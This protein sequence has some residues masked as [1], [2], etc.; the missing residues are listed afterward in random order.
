MAKTWIIPDIHGYAE[1][2]RFL[3]E[4]QIKP[5]KNDYLI[6]L[7]DYI[8]RGGDSKGVIDIIMDLESQG[9]HVTAL[10]GNHEDVCLKAWEEAKKQKE[11]F[12]GRSSLHMQAYW[13]VLGGRKTL[14]SF[15]VSRTDEIPGK[16]IHWMRSLKYFVELDDFIAVH[17]GFNFK[18]DDPFSDTHAM[19]WIRDYEII[20]EKIKH[21]I[22]IH[23]HSPANLA[24]IELFI[25]NPDNFLFINLDNGIYIR[26]VTGY[27]NLVALELN[28]ME[29]K[30]QP[31]VDDEVV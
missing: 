29:Y 3:L 27:G 5:G 28:S 23:G 24:L 14:D 8:D 19:I 13:E 1:T 16:Y 31:V 7:G 21:K 9:Y 6:F 10:K 25:K 4:H 17:A 26:H 30:I 20:P 15:G 22:I 2:L 12:G 11:F 18:T